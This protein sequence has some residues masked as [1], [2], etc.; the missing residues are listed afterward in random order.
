VDFIKQF[1]GKSVFH[2]SDSDLDGVSCRLLAEYFIKP[3]SSNYVPYNSS[4]R[5][6]VEFPFEEAIEYDIVLFTDIAPPSQEFIDKLNEHSKVIIVDHHQSHRDDLGDI[7]NYYFSLDFCATKSFYNLLTKGKRRKLSLDMY[8]DLVNIYD[9]YITDSEDW[10]SAKNLHNTMYGYV[11]WRF[12][13]SQSDTE[14]YEKFIDIQLMKI[15]QYDKFFFTA[16]EKRIIAK[17]AIKEAN[18]YKQAKKH[19]QFRVDGEGNN[20]AY[21]EFSSKISLVAHKLMQEYKGEIEYIVIFSLF[22]KSD[23]KFSLRSPEDFDTKYITEKWGG[24]GHK[25]ASG[26]SFTDPEI[27]QKFREGKIH[28]I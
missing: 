20:Y 17:S 4:D 21:T 6:F 18:M 13:N 2:A 14:R 24:G 27:F 19:L 15:D 1:E 22:R 8:T 5:S 10:Q 7:D 12:I 26:M 9:L 25:S 11:D 16:Y 23:M 3:I 28:L